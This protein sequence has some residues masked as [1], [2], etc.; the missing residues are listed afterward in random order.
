MKENN[1]IFV[2]ESGMASRLQAAAGVGIEIL[3]VED[4]CT[5]NERYGSV[6]VF[7]DNNLD[8]IPQI[9]EILLLNPG[10]TF[11]LYYDE[12]L[13]PTLM[14]QYVNNGVTEFVC[15]DD[16]KFLEELISRFETSGNESQLNYY[17]NL[18]TKFKDIG[19]I[20][21]STKMAEIFSSVEKVANSSSTVLVYGENGTGKELIARSIHYFSPRRPHKFVAVNTGAIPENLL[22]DELFGHVKGSFTS[23]MKDR[24]GKFEF[25]DRGSIFLDEISNMPPMLQVKLLRVLQEREFERIGDN[26][27]VK[28]DVRVIA[29]TNKNI[30]EL[31][32]SGDF[33]EDLYYRL[34]V[35]PLFLPPLRERRAD[36]PVLT[37]YF[38]MK[39]C[40]I[41]DLPP[42]RMTL[43]AIRILQSYSWPGNIRQ[44]ENI[45]ERMVV[46]NPDTPIFMPRDVPDEVKPDIPE[47]DGSAFVPVEIPDEGFSLTEVVRNVEKQL[48]L[49]SLEKTAWN[50]QKAA[51][52]LKVKRTTLIEKIKKIQ[53]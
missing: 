40:R 31:V 6:V 16:V 21:N 33:R 44:L 4:L 41:N 12:P 1:K 11:I 13:P 9:K 45:I 2:L 36:I 7:I 47:D 28:V 53:E 20:T 42:K 46:L 14:V 52:L 50:K 3:A 19:I 5:K 37:N 17:N 18:I 48:I 27:T 34:N 30:K 26:Q 38:L 35:I 39:Y 22:E 24:K 8:Y 15:L 51:E 10:I 43:P 29:A 25:A 32:E 23:A 49:K